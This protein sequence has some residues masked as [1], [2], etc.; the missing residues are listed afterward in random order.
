MGFAYFCLSKAF[1]FRYEQESEGAL[2]Q[3]LRKHFVEDCK[4]DAKKTPKNIS[5]YGGISIVSK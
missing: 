1:E 4:K 5:R 2:S 3:K